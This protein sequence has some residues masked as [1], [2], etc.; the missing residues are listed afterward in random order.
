MGSV[1]GFFLTA[2][3]LLFHRKKAGYPLMPVFLAVEFLFYL[4]GVIGFII[5]GYGI[6][7]QMANPDVLLR[8][9]LFIGY[10]NFDA[11]GYCLILLMRYKHDFQP[12]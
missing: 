8:I 12:A 9:V 6:F 1:F 2:S 5:Y 7:F 10:L 11:S 4:W 3:F